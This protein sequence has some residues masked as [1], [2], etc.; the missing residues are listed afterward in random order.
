MKKAQLDENF[1]A[2]NA[3]EIRVYNFDEVSREYIS[4]SIEI[5]ATG[6]GIPANSCVDAPLNNKDGMA[7]CRSEEFLNWE[8]ISD[9][10]GE[11]IFDITTGKPFLVKLLGEYPANTTT[12]QPTSIYDK[13]DG[14]NW[15]LDQKTKQKIDI[16]NAEQHRKDILNEIDK[17]TSDWRVELLLGNISDKN[18]MKLSAWMTYKSLIKNLDLSKNFDVTWPAPPVM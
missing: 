6:V 2:V 15:V 11:I 10:R 12:K 14:S 18:K 1:I 16:E 4:S 13:W 8:Y 9:H 3:G 17:I 7:V 5:L